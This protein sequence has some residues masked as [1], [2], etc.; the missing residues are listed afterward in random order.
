MKEADALL[1]GLFVCEK[2]CPIK[3]RYCLRRLRDVTKN[4]GYQNESG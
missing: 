1:M 3:Y 2:Q 4:V